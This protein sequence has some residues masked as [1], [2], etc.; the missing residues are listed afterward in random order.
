MTMP[1]QSLGARPRAGKNAFRRGGPSEDPQMDASW[2]EIWAPLKYIYSRYWAEAKGLLALVAVIVFCSAVAGVAGPYLFSR[3]IDTMQAGSWGEAIVWGFV[4]YGLLFGLSQAL[5]GMVNYMA[6]MSAENLNFIAGT[7]FFTRLLKK[8]VAFF[9]EYNPAEIQQAKSRGQ[10]AVYTLVQLALIV[11]IPGLI[12]ITMT[13]FVLG[14]SI[15]LEIV[16]IVFVYGAA[17]IALTF[18]S[19]RWT[20]PYLD[21]AIKADQA[22]SKFVGNSINAMETLRYF[23]G[24]Q[25]IAGRFSEQAAEVRKSW[26]SFGKRRISIAVIFGLM[27]AVQI[28]ITFAVLLPRYRAGELSVG[29]V[30]LFDALLLQ[31]NR[32]FQM[33]GSSIDDVLRSY[34]RFIPFAKMWGA[35]EETDA[36]AGADFR[37]EV[38]RIVFD[39]VGFGYRD[40][41]VVT[42]VSF[43][44]ERGRLN[45]LTGETGSGKTTL[46][47]L[48]LK[49]LEPRNGRILVDGTPLS[50]IARADWYSV[51]GVVPQEIM[52][53]NDTLTANIVLG[54]PLDMDRLRRAAERASILRFI[55]GLPEQ[56]E[57]KVGE[58]GL[59][60][61]GGERQRVAIAR[62]LYADPQILFLDEASSALDERTEAEIMGE[63]RSLAHEMTI[64]AITH[65]RTVIETG[66]NVVEL[67]EGAARERIAA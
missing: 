40:E 36:P 3:L 29:D 20:R 31:L 22:N 12:Q 33:I 65:R 15:N 19:N 7:A 8:T 18:F 35:P 54:R 21:A 23:G 59:K 60:L 17:F 14:A 16:V 64:I 47:K 57:T 56:F 48:A 34:S 45:F 2:P 38:G 27:L 32:P 67:K 5:S 58:R 53:L 39:H 55:D 9:I 50:E 24:D 63:L 49:S 44:A 46:F 25:W 37:L 13:L 1:A 66:D 10:N 43:V 41:A 6:M 61:S 62:A 52:L 51:I 11:L 30:V 26:A 42:D 4:G 28:G